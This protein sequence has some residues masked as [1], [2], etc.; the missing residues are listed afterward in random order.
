MSS[1]YLPRGRQGVI[2]YVFSCDDCVEHILI[3]VIL[4]GTPLATYYYSGRHL[5]PPP[6][7]VFTGHK[8][9][10]CRRGLNAHLSCSAATRY[11]RQEINYVVGMDNASGSVWIA[12]HVFEECVDACLKNIG[13]RPGNTVAPNVF[14]PQIQRQDNV[15]NLSVV[16]PASNYS[17]CDYGE[18]VS[19]QTGSART[20]EVLGRCLKRPWV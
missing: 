17:L 9:L 14:D 8:I 1:A 7:F 13:N 18:V 5:E 15:S 11:T 3:G 4:R 16:C 2:T 10:R 19:I 12:R 6:V 20:S